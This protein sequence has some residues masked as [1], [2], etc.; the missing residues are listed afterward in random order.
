MQNLS[1]VSSTTASTTT[2]GTAKRYDAGTYV[3]DCPKEVKMVPVV[4][5]RTEHSVNRLEKKL[6]ENLFSQPYACICLFLLIVTNR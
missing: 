2:D 3:S 1:D 5:T 4:F 6:Y